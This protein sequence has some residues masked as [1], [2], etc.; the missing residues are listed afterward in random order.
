MAL[1]YIVEDDPNIR[2]IETIALKNSNYTVA[3]FE[4]ASAFFSR[5]EDILPDL[6]L[7]DLMLPDQDG[8]EIVRRLRKN[9]LT[10]KI[11]VIMVTARTTEMDLVKGLDSGIGIPKDQQERIFERF[12]RVDKSRSRET[13]GT[14]LGLAI[15]KHIAE[16]HEAKISVDSALG[17]GT[18][19]TVQF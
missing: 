17:K 5:L 2:E 14:G 15:V 19:I 4:H 1:I 8:F 7:L 13:G 11:P 18:C 10:A 3:A 6:V 9:P 16:I 12:Y